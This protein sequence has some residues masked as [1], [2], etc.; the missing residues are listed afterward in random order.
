MLQWLLVAVT[1]AA[2]SAAPT[3]SSGAV[4]QASAPAAPL[5]LSLGTEE[6]AED[7]EPAL[8]VFNAAP[9]FEAEDQTPSGRFL[10]ATEVKPILEATKANWVAVREFNGQDL[11]YV[12]HI[13]SWRCGLHQM[14]LSVNGGPLEV[15]DLPDCHIDT[16]APAAIT[17][18]DGNPYR[19]F[20]LGSIQSVAVELLYDDL[21]TTG[22]AFERK[23]V[24]MP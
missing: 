18:E 6:T 2:N 20:P 22:G 13:W 11:L 3:P 14:K 21:T 8:P 7:A 15:W 17:P 10:T 16:N 12:T 9:A 24:L 1:L 5:D 23:M 19:S 4:E